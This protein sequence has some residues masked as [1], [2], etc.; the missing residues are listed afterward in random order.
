MTTAT[1]SNQPAGETSAEAQALAERYVDVWHVTG[2]AARRAAIAA[3]W[4]PNGV[5]YVRTLEARGYDA[6]EARVTGSH[7]KNVQIAGNR[8]RALAAVAL[9]NVVT[10]QWEML[11]AAGEADATGFEILLLDEDG[12]IVTDYQFVT[13]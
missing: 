6:L 2:P 7:E 1:N 4:A 13:G 8:F 5:H 9:R 11:T 12:K 10:F 3:L